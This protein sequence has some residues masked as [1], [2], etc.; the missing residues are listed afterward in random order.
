MKTTLR[1]RR[2]FIALAGRQGSCSY[3]EHN[4]ARFHRLGN[5][6]LQDLAELFGLQ[7][8][9][10]DLRSNMAGIAVSG[11]VTLHSDGL[12][13]QFS[14]SCVRGLE[15]LYR[16]CKHRKDYTGGPNCW[17]PWSALEDLTVTAKQLALTIRQSKP[18]AN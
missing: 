8:N 1:E 3:N 12:Y 14:Q 15:I 10:F 16:S 17:L 2:S 18:A 9:Q 13:I 6:I 11:E 4:K 7:P 5:R